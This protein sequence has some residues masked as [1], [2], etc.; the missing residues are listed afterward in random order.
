MGV[1]GDADKSLKGKEKQKVRLELGK[2]SLVWA[3]EEG[4]TRGNQGILTREISHVKLDQK[5]NSD[6]ACDTYAAI[7]SKR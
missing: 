4:K 1:S 2:A 3:G 6:G 7:R 5:R